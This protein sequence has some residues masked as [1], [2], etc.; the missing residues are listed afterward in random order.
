VQPQQRQPLRRV[1]VLVA[2]ILLLA[3]ASACNQSRVSSAP[4]PRYADSA[5]GMARLMRDATPRITR[6]VDVRAAFADETAVRGAVVLIDAH[7]GRRLP[8]E[9][10]RRRPLLVRYV[11]AEAARQAAVG[12]SSDPTELR[13]RDVLFLPR[14]FPAKAEKDYRQATY[15]GFQ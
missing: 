7:V 9:D 12:D 5:V 13:G 1:T 15:V 14:H 8:E 3:P 4:A 2:T 11:S 6:V 10:V